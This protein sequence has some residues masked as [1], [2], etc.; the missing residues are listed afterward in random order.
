MIHKEIASNVIS[1]IVLCWPLTAAIIS[2]REQIN[3]KMQH[4]HLE[5]A[6]S[7]WPLWGFPCSNTTVS[8]EVTCCFSYSLF[9][10]GDI[11]LTASPV[12]SPHAYGNVIS[13]CTHRGFLLQGIRQ[14]QLSPKQAIVL[15]MTTSQVPVR[16]Y[17]SLVCFGLP[18]LKLIILWVYGCV[19]WHTPVVSVLEVSSLFI[20][21]LLASQHLCSLYSYEWCSCCFQYWCFFFSRKIPLGLSLSLRLMHD[22]AFF[23]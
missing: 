21:S 14:L 23:Y 3:H 4:L 15:S 1:F 2:W 18:F 12:V 10:L 9:D 16:T 5:S 17:S 19:N 11:I 20:I 6:S 13:V 8:V 22:Q 7:S